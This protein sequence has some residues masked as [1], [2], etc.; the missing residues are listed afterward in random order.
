MNGGNVTVSVDARQTSSDG[1]VSRIKIKSLGMK[2]ELNGRTFLF[3]TETDEEGVKTRWNV[4]YSPQ[5]AQISR[6]GP[7]SSSLIFHENEHCRSTYITPYGSFLVD[8]DTRRFNLSE[9]GS[10]SSI[11][12][13]Y[14]LAL[15]GEQTAECRVEIN[16][17]SGT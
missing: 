3:F 2:K 15:E 11:E 4:K 9:N 12:I 5:G 14:L 8:I 13:L 16:I 10:R 6:D 17:C 1:Q 7:V